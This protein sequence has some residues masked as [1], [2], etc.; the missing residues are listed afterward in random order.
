MIQQLFN[1]LDQDKD[2]KITKAEIN[3]GAKSNDAEIV[4]KSFEEADIDDNKLIDYQEF[5][6][7]MVAFMHKNK[8]NL[9][10]IF[11]EFDK[12][13]DGCITLDELKYAFSKVDPSA[14]PSDIEAKF[15]SADINKD[16]KITFEE[17]KALNG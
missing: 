7:I 3:Q 2:G 5:M 9:Q 12:D 17:F 14:T 16:G 4:E 15:K 1:Q 10:G 8:N 11:N 6:Q 13:G